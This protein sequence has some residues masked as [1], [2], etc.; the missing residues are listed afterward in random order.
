MKPLK[1]GGLFLQSG[2]AA[3]CLFHTFKQNLFHYQFPSRTTH[4]LFFN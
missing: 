3:G 4:K 2:D 1:F